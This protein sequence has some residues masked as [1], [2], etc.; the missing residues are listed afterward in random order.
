MNTL[1]AGIIDL[2]EQLPLLDSLIARLDRIQSSFFFEK[3]LPITSAVLGEPNVDDEWYGKK[4]LLD[5]IAAKADQSKY[6]FLVAVTNVKMTDE[7]EKN[8]KPDKDYFSISNKKNIAVISVNQKVYKRASAGTK[9][10][11]FVAYLAIFEL[12]TMFIK[13]TLTHFNSVPCLFNECEDR[14][15]IAECI[16]SGKICAACRAVLKEQNVSDQ[17]LKDAE[18]IIRWCSRETTLSSLTA[19]FRNPIV[20]L[21]FG[22]A[23]GWVLKTYVNQKFSLLVLLIAIVP[24]ILVFFRHRLLP[25]RWSMLPK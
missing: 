13:R 11:Q 10:V 3:G 4:K 8:S 2:G 16:D 1:K 5:L 9:I 12:F 21:V 24:P 14:D 7:A 15:F 17:M 25:R 20:T 22:A 19:P 18:K 23:L 6:A